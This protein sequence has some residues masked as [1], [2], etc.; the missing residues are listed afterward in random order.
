MAH[1]KNIQ[2]R[3]FPNVAQSIYKNSLDKLKFWI[4]PEDIP[5]YEPY[6]DV[7]EFYGE[8]NK[9][10]IYYNIYAEDKKWSGSLGEIIIGLSDEINSM[11]LA[12]R[13]AEARIKCE[14]KCMKGSPCHICEH[15][16]E[17]SQT[18]EKANLRITLDNNKEDIK[19]NG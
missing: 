4:R 17:L 3:V 10:E 11:T 7:C 18:L 12:P 2:I 13:F 15:M 19:N 6:V 1:D 5:I 16:I 9:Q 8:E 14:R